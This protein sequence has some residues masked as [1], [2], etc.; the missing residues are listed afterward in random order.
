MDNLPKPPVEIV[1]VFYP[2]K[3]VKTDTVFVVK[4]QPLS[5]NHVPPNAVIHITPV[6]SSFDR[7]AGPGGD[8]V[9]TL[10]IQVIH[11][12]DITVPVKEKEHV[13]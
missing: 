9:F 6:A 11:I 7:E 4:G 10:K 12:P 3:V 1:P 2:G 13:R 5:I 8:Y